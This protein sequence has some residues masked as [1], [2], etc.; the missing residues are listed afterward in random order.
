MSEP[1]KS[2]YFTVRKPTQLGPLDAV[3]P[4]YVGF[5]SGFVDDGWVPVSLKLVVVCESPLDQVN[6]IFFGP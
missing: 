3:P 2:L 6:Q 4:G 5:P 1:A